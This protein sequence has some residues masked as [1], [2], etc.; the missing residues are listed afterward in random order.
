MATT[1][2]IRAAAALA[3]ALLAGCTA[4]SP[5]W[6]SRFGDAS[7][8]LRAQQLID[9]DA[10]MRNQGVLPPGDGRGLREAGDRYVD[11][12]KAPPPSNV[13]NIGVGGG[14]GGGGR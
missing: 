12:F 14:S 6:D 9:P 7:R 13:I 8:Q 4:T 5:G 11:S 1:P 3:V 10:P 2:C